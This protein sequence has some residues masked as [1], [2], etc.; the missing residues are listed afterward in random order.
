MRAIAKSFI[1]SNPIRGA[2][3][4]ENVAKELGQASVAVFPSRWEAFGI[5]AL[6]SL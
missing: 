4:Q 5:A 3:S 6:E 1:G 2:T